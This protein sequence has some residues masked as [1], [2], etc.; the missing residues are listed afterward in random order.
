MSKPKTH[1]ENLVTWRT[2]LANL[3]P[4]LDQMPHLREQHAAF[5]AL[6]ERAERLEAQQSR[7]KA[8]L[9]RVNQERT[10]AALEGRRLRNRIAQG[11]KGF[12]D[13]DNP[14]LVAFGVPPRPR[15]QRRRRLTK[16]E[17]AARVASA[18]AGRSDDPAT[19]N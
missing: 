11:L 12:F 17:K 19:V 2:M 16:D 15:N 4:L 14:Q 9:Q 18:A 1:K 8:K 10:A 13:L 5:S 6:V 3:A 7:C